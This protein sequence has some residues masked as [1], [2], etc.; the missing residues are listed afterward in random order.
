MADL[1]AV[2]F[3]NSPKDV[4]E[5]TKAVESNEAQAGVTWWERGTGALHPDATW[6]RE[7]A[8]TWEVHR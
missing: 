5:Y 4:E 8:L 7:F 2:Y 3:T 6:A 1:Q